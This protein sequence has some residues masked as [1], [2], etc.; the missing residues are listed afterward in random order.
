MN[1]SP[2]LFPGQEQRDSLF[3]AD[4]RTE[5]EAHERLRNSKYLE[6]R[7][8]SCIV[9]GKVLCLYGVVSSY[10][11]RQIAQAMLSGLEGVEEIYNRLEVVFHRQ[12]VFHWQVET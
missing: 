3:A 4:H 2:P 6:L 9:Q 10:Y 8:I 1:I 7:R 11:L 12:V 5:H